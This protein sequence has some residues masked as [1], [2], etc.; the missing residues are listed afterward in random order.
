MFDFVGKNKRLLQF[1]LALII[2]PTFAFFGIQ[3]YEGFFG[4]SNDVAEVAG[5]PISIQEF[6]RALDQQRNRL[7][8]AFG[9]NIDPAMFDT[10]EARRELLDSLV[11]R[12]VLIDYAFKRRMLVSDEQIRD[13]IAN[14]P[15]FQDGG[16]F[17]RERYEA[18]LRAQNM[19]PAGFEAQ[20]RT[21]MALEQLTQS[22][23][24][25]AFVSRT[26]AQQ[27]ARERAATREV[28]RTLVNAG[29]FAG[30]VEVSAEEIDAYYAD[31]PQEFETPEQVRAAYVVLDRDSIAASIE[32]SDEEIQQQYDARVAPQLQAREEVRARANEVLSEVR[33]DPSRF[34]ELAAQHS[35]DPGSAEQ[36]GDLGFFGRGAMVKAFED[37]VWRLKPGEISSLV[38]TE[39]GFHIIQLNEV[40]GGERRASHIL[41]SAP[42]VTADPATARKEIA[43]ELR[44][45]QLART[46]PEAAEAF[47]NLAYE[48]P[49]TLE[50]LVERFGLKVQE[51]G[52]LSR[53]SGRPP[54]DNAQLLDSL[55]GPDA[56]EGK[57][58]TEAVEV[59]P[60][61]LVVARVIE[62]KPQSLRPLADVREE[63]RKTLL[64]RKA[65]E[66]A[67]QAGQQ[68]LEALRKGEK[69]AVNWNAPRKVSRENPGGL[70]PQA[71][72]AV[73]RAD[74][75]QLPAY[76]GVETSSGYAIYRISAVDTPET[77]E[78]QRE[79]AAANA[80]AQ[81]NAQQELEAF[82]DT[83]RERADVEVY[84]EQMLQAGR[85]GR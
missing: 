45:Q 48:Q 55:F 58:N 80:L 19:S 41:F 6:E 39:F 26:M 4:G 77:V 54:L 25:S 38:E 10:P 36:G 31:H 66:Q 37:A 83:L 47:A 60:G 16:Q 68:K 46:F 74:T 8:E 67:H 23:A 81:L 33:K 42:A 22:L 65:L 9:G 75:T 24:Q 79:R 43:E 63:I 73:F 52:W 18:L 44:R 51:S 62:H 59:A 35:E 69:T 1:F 2:V 61:Q 72:T 7:R 27:F 84:E 85:R 34:A 14:Y 21:D 30:K 11:S 3:S 29:E 78:A 82:V 53:T 56:I 28:S 5:Q 12:R 20:L 76:V 49:D 32:V 13:F 17:S 71:L 64:E 57:Q 70:D 15:A 50:P 40:K